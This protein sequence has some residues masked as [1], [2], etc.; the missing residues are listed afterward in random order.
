VQYIKQCAASFQGVP[1][2]RLEGLQ[3]VKYPINGYYKTHVDRI[4]DHCVDDLCQKTGDRET[5]L[6]LYLQ[7]DCKGGAT[8]FSEM[9]LPGGVDEE[10][11]CR[12]LDCDDAN[13]NRDGNEQ[14][15]DANG[16]GVR[17]EGGRTLKFRPKAG[18]AIFWENLD[19]FGRGIWKVAHAGMPVTEGTKIGM[20]ICTRERAP[21]DYHGGVRYQEKE[22]LDG[23]VETTSQVVEDLWEELGFDKIEI[24]DVVEPVEEKFS[25]SANQ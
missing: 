20:N 3:V 1:V 23:L 24:I 13:G 11:W 18:N 19:E 25:D 17:G 8:E 2:Q 16:T 12:F 9:A 4:G 22:V 14:T 5:S 15:T 7:A 10:L 6:F 21:G